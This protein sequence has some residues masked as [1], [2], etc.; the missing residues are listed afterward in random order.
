MDKGTHRR[1]FRDSATKGQRKQRGK[2]T[3][4]D[5]KG[6]IDTRDKGTKSEIGEGETWIEGQPHK[7]RKGRVEKGNASGRQ[8]TKPGRG[9]W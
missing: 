4:R 2:S 6:R 3:K 8:D 7:A 9:K 5:E 1:R